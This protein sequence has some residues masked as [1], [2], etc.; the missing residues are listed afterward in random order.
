MCQRS[1]CANFDKLQGAVSQCSEQ[2]LWTSIFVPIL[3]YP[4]TKHRFSGMCM[5]TVW[6]VCSLIVCPIKGR[7]A[8]PF[9][10]SHFTDI[11]GGD[12]RQCWIRGIQHEYCPCLAENL[13]ICIG[14]VCSSQS[15][16]GRAVWHRILFNHRRYSRIAALQCFDRIIVLLQ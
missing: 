5:I 16:S 8:P 2:H 11:H 4:A 7:K 12:W 3:S 1:F 10:W 6:S 9:I 13:P 14:I 15:L